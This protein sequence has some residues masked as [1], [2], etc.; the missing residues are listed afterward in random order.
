MV[1]QYD[2]TNIKAIA[3]A[4]RAKNGTT[5]KY[6]TSEMADAIREISDRNA[7]L[8]GS[9][10]TVSSDVTKI[11]DYALA[12]CINLTSADFPLATSMG[13]YAFYNCSNL[14]TINLPLLQSF[15]SMALGYCT[16]LKGAVFP[17]VTSL[18]DSAL[19]GCKTAEMFDFHQ[20]M[21]IG[22]YAFRYCHTL[23]ALVLRSGT[24][25]T[26]PAETVFQNCYHLY[27][28]T[29][30]TYNPNGLKDGYI[31]VPSALVASYK[32]NSLWS[33]FSTR[34]RALESYTVDGTTT[35]ALDESKI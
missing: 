13:T 28:T 35:G 2:D 33:T 6:K 25:C 22:N 7:M 31:Y 19:I 23:K 32:A 9:I 27:G 30:S 20:Y 34:F 15:G 8:D 24:L 11:N 14:E 12:K 1:K 10:T 4:I 26:I 21:T 29:D 18:G 16:A 17:E 5:N 3:D